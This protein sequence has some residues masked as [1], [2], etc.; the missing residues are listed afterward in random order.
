MFQ[1]RIENEVAV[2]LVG[3][4]DEVVAHAKV[5]DA[6][7]FLATPDAGDGV[8]GIAE[9]E[10]LRARRDGALERVPVDRPGAGG[11]FE[12]DLHRCARGVFRRAHEGHCSRL[13]EIC[14]ACS[15][16]QERCSDIASG[17]HSRVVV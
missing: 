1:R 7:E 2:D 17:K 4:E 10:Q 9:V 14:N 5:G 11:E 12:G 13:R 8:V 16:G 3:T 6:H 15:G